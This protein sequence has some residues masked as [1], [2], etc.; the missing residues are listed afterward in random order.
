M[1]NSERKSMSIKAVVIDLESGLTRKQIRE[2]YELTHADMKTLFSH[3]KLKG[4][5]TQSSSILEI[6]D[7]LDE[8]ADARPLEEEPVV[9]EEVSTPEA[10]TNPEV[11]PL[12][13]E[14]TP[15]VATED[16]GTVPVVEEVVEDRPPFDRVSN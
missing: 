15:V 3:E 4:R 14:P 5:R 10:T 2:K 8:E 12:P 7:D 16:W 1:E 11:A 13:V 9:E 6:I